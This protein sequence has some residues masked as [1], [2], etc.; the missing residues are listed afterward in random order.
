MTEEA[1]KLKRVQLDLSLKAFATL[2]EL[3]ASLDCTSYAEVIKT[4]LRILKHLTKVRDSGGVLMVKK[5]DGTV[6]ELSLL[7]GGE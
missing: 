7:L 6:V 5:P 2:N 4:G 1:P 3:K